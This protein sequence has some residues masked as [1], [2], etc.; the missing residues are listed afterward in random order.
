MTNDHDVNSQSL[1]EWLVPSDTWVADNRVQVQSIVECNRPANLTSFLADELRDSR[2]P[3]EF[4]IECAQVLG[5]DETSEIIAELM[6]GRQTMRRGYFGE[7]L[8][9]CCLRDFDGYRL[10][11]QKLRSMISSD[12][13]LPGIDILGAH[14]VDG[15]IEALALAEAKLRTNREPRIVLSAARELIDDFRVER[16]NVLISTLIK[17]QESGD[18]MF[19]LMLDYLQRRRQD[20]TEDFPYVFLVLEAGNWIDND[21]ELLDDLM[22]LPERFRVTVIEIHEL[23][24]LV[25]D[26]YSLV[27]VLADRNDDE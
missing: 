2:F 7:T 16:P 5:I 3:P 13:S 26:A 27:G 17:L 15:R 9:A 22:P 6:P 4:I 18:P 10:P 25:D 19:P 1:P 11:V 21:V 23:A 20:E 24:Q 14:F 12:Q 8:A